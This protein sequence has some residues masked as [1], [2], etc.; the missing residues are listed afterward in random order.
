MGISQTG[1]AMVSQ[2]DIP[3]VRPANSGAP[4]FIEYRLLEPDTIT[5]G[6]QVK[7]AN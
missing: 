5:R 6:E 2:P 7:L 4:L 3:I 1:T